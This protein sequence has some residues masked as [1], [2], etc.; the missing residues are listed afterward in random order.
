MRSEEFSCFLGKRRNK[1]IVERGSTITLPTEPEF[2]CSISWGKEDTNVHYTFMDQ[3]LKK[4]DTSRS[5]DL[6]TLGFLR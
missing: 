3:G 6:L 1:L 4:Q 2:E 5:E